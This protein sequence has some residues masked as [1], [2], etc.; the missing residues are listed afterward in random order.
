MWI[1]ADN[2]EQW[3]VKIKVLLEEKENFILKRTYDYI[4]Y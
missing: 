3:A 2:V 1:M 4:N